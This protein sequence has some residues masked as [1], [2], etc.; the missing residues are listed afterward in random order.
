MSSCIRISNWDK[1][2]ATQQILNNRSTCLCQHKRHTRGTN[3]TNGTNWQQK[4]QTTQKIA[5]NGTQ[6]AH[7]AQT[8]TSIK[9]RNTIKSINITHFRKNWNKGHKR[10]KK[11]T[12][13]TN[14][15][16]PHIL[17]DTN[18]TNATK[19]TKSTNLD[20]NGTNTTH[21]TNATNDT[22]STQLSTADQFQSLVLPLFFLFWL[23]YRSLTCCKPEKWGWNKHLHSAC[24]IGTQNG[25]PNWGYL[26]TR[27]LRLYILF[28][29]YIWNNRKTIAKYHFYLVIT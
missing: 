6:M 27:Q 4:A 23:S 24:N 25:L 9:H 3:N 10:H 20:T 2:E 8:L 17:M 19:S 29:A 12:N 7:T 13:T 16:K 18:G 15:T 26:S 21:A 5:T 28:C 22:K 1:K 11:D 14:V